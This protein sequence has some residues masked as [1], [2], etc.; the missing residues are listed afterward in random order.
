MN[1]KIEGGREGEHE[2]QT[3]NKLVRVGIP[4][5]IEKNSDKSFTHIADDKEYKESLMQKVQ[6]EVDEFL[7]DPNKE[8]IADILE[9]L[10]AI[11]DF[12]GTSKEE[13]E[14]IRKGKADKRGGFKK[15]I[16]IDRT[17]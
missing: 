10:Y 3:F 8:E 6:E 5:I 2:P 16:I 15:R 17:E 9:V 14:S 7:K 4:E 1:D 12:E 13:I 11:C